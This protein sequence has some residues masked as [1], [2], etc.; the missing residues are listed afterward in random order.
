MALEDAKELIQNAPDGADSL[1]I[2]LENMLEL[3]RYQAERL[4][5]NVGQRHSLL[6]SVS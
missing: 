4:H 6:E 2:I 1:A 5:L 3:S